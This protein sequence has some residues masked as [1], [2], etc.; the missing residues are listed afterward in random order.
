VLS[1]NASGPGQLGSAITIGK[2]TLTVVGIADS[3]TN[4]A[5]GWVL[6]AELPSGAVVGTTPYLA[7][8]QSEQSNVAPW[9]PFIV[10][11]GVMALAISVLI[12]VAGALA[13]ASWAARSGTAAALRT[14]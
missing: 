3:V 14:G 5:D 1:V 12:A 11:F 2:Q 6:P 10:A 9:V 8:R 4:T 13:P 7:V